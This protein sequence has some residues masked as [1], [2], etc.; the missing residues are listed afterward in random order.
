MSCNVARFEIPTSLR[1]TVRFAS[2]MSHSVLDGRMTFGGER[3]TWRATLAKGAGVWGLRRPCHP[4]MDPLDG[5]S[6]DLGSFSHLEKEH[7]FLFKK[8][9][10]EMVNISRTKHQKRISFPHFFLN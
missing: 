2:Q 10:C 8:V 6:K 5:Q 3:L 4:E 1:S 9:F 7:L